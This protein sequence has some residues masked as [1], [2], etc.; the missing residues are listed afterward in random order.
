M[1]R[2]LAVTI[3]SAVLASSLVGLSVATASTVSNPINSEQF[4]MHVPAIAEGVDPG[5]SYGTIRIWD[6]GVAWGQVE[7]KKGEYWW[8]G[9]D[10]AIGNANSQ[11]VKILYVLGATPTWAATN[12]NQ[13]NYP[14]K[15][16]ASMPNMKAWKSWVRAVVNRY[17][18]SIDSYQIWNEAN[19]ADFW[20]GS[21]K[22]MANL[23]KAATKIIRQGDPTAKIVSAST[24][25]RLDKAYE[26][27]FPAYLKALKKAKWPVDAIA[28][29]SYP[30]GKG[31]PATRAGLIEKVKTQMKKSKVPASKELWDTE[32]NYGIPGPGKI[33]GQTISGANAASWVAQT[34]LDNLR[35]GVN[36]AYWYFWAP[37]TARIG[38]E[39]QDGSTGAI[40]YQSV[41][42]WMN[43]SYYNCSTGALNSC[44][45]GDNDNPRVVV[46]ASTGTQAYTVPA[47]AS[48]SC[49]AL[50]QCT[51]V[52]PGQSI[53]IGSMPTWFGTPQSQK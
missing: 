34:Y 21:P 29:H 41:Y 12:K 5:V 28:V 19:L 23:T 22:Q 47:N 52:T 13:G 18:D 14:N 9:L 35:L 25:V 50:N 45:F 40:G 43:E 42:N 4:G 39:M 8:N 1:R 32:V 30:D 11:N 33:K 17:G 27:F 31:T 48:V 36:R 3:S 49:N 37:D 26:K 53:S 46:W 38:I 16:A 24:T 51:P 20:Q 6:S 2:V 10:R 44:N 7:Q 15:G